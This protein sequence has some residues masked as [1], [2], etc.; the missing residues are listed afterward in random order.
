MRF[1]LV[2]AAGVLELLAGPL[3][4]ADL[5]V[6]VVLDVRAGTAHYLTELTL[7]NRGTSRA[8]VSFTWVA[9]QGGG[10]G[11][12]DGAET[13]EG[14]RQLVIPDA[15][16][17]LRQKGLAIAAE[18]ARLGTLR[19]VFTGLSSS[20]DASVLARTTT[21]VP[22]GGRAGLAY[23]GVAPA[24][25]FSAAP[26]FVT[27]LRQDSRDRSAVAVQNAGG[28]GDGDVTVRLTFVAGD[29]ADAGRALGSADVTLPP[30]GFAQSPL[31]S[32]V[33]G[34]SG[35]QGHVRAER[36][37]G[38]APWYAYGV[39][40]D[41]VT[42][43]GSF[44]VP[45]SA[46]VAGPALGVT[47]PAVVDTGRFV[48]EVGAGLAALPED[49]RPGEVTVLV[50]TD[51]HENASREQSLAAVKRLVEERTAAGWT[52]VFLGAALDV[53]GEAGGLGVAVGNTQMFEASADGAALAFDSLSQGTRNM[54]GKVRRAERVD[55][56]DFFEEGKPAESH[57]RR[58]TGR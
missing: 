11:T 55:K 38:S 30:G 46:R 9:T 54:R 58:T 39:V 15:V 13:I 32:I 6:P 14:G 51:G 1:R 25:L 53:Y 40:N 26:V 57:R 49:Q 31:T 17:Y 3:P 41:Q 19:V 34:L 47:L 23:P 20:Q 56:A 37:S 7:T 16:A 18:G 27:G 50:L 8:R 42:S 5:V 48:T 52:F 35:R 22:T 43:D 2:L 12:L 10:S 24:Q 21:P 45:V 28:S 29:G 4:A 44:L 33:P 36:V